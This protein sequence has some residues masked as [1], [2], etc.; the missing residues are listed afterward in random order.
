MHTPKLIDLFCGCGGLSLGATRAGFDL[1][2]GVDHDKRAL[3]A[4]SVNF[5]Q[6]KHARLDLGNTS[7]ADLLKAADVQHGAV[8]VIA[9][10]PPCQGFSVIG[11]RDSADNRNQLIVD[12]FRI[13]AALE[14]RVFILENVPGVLH[15]RFSG[16]LENALGLVK[17]KYSILEPQKITAFQVGAPTVRT[18]IILVGFRSDMNALSDD[19][20]TQQITACEKAPVVRHALDGLPSDINPIPSGARA[21]KRVVRI[22]RKGAFFDATTNR[23]PTKVGAPAALEEYFTRGIVTGCLGSL[24]SKDL[25]QRY[26]DLAFG[27]TDPTTKSTKLDP[28]GYCPTLRAGTGPERG[29]FQA[30]R[31]IHYLRPRVITP[32]EAARLQGF[33]DWFQFD[34]TKWHSFRQLGN[35]VSPLVAEA[36]F[37]PIFKALTNA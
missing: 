29:S 25:I 32:R 11:K 10:G 36:V 27:A 26:A 31:P 21:G 20:L 6:S 2:L 15:P 9:G 12:F 17:R 24:H 8:D 28:N 3:A 1:V 19:F 16:I 7:A 34:V 14:P 30:V 22:E 35:S 5:P 4:H 13:V 23:V 37:Q 18:R 33:P